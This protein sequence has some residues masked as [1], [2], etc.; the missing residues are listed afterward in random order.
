[1]PSSNEELQE[2]EPVDDI[3]ERRT[4]HPPQP[5]SPRASNLNGNTN[6]M[7]SANRRRGCGRGQPAGRGHTRHH[8]GD[9]VSYLRCENSEPSTGW[10][11][12]RETCQE[13]I[14]EERLS[15]CLF[16][17]REMLFEKASI[18]RLESECN[19][20]SFPLPGQQCFLSFLNQSSRQFETA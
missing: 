18:E 13:I 4:T 16:T 3:Q 19:L 7:F 8:T 6:N 12:L 17:Q 14:Y 11:R 10:E 1:M 15:E 2:I 9:L 20:R 5:T